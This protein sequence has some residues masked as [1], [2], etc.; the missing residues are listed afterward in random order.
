MANIERPIYNNF[1]STNRSFCGS[2]AENRSTIPKIQN[3]QI[4]SDIKDIIAIAVDFPG[5]W[6]DNQYFSDRNINPGADTY[7]CA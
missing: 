6:F 5:Y 4:I 1:S 7:F 3:I 2:S